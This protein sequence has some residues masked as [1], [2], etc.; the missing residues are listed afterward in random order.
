MSRG[1]AADEAVKVFVSYSH[2]DA[3]KKD[4][5]LT[6]L[7]ALPRELRVITDVWHDRQMYPGDRFDEDIFARIGQAD[8]F[9]ALI[10]RYYLASDYCREEMTGALREAE[11]RG[12]RVVPVIVGKTASWRDYPI[13]RHLALPPDGRAPTDWNDPDEHWAA[14]EQGLKE[15]FGELA[16][17]R[18]TP[19]L[20]PA[21]RKPAPPTTK[22]AG[23]D[24]PDPEPDWASDWGDDRYGRWLEF[25]VDDSA[26][27]APVV[28][29]LRWI[30]PGSFTMGSPATEAGR[31]DDET[32]HRV[33]LSRGFWLADTAC[34]QALW[35]AVMG[36]NP[37]TFE[38]ADRPV[39]QVSWADV[40]QFIARLNERLPG[41]AACLPTEAQ[42]EYAC[43]AGTR[44][45]FSTGETITR[46]QANYDGKETVAVEALPC[47]DWG[48][49]QM[50][51]NVWEWCSDWYDYYPARAVTDPP[52]PDSG[53]ERVLRGGSWNYNPAEVRSA[54]R[55]G[56]APG[57]RDN[58]IGFRLARSP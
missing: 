7:R 41:L 22:P 37:S 8:I 33:T 16:K 3:D 57:Y 45:P 46:A 35:R 32:P 6:C 40:Q 27:G 18:K 15:L 19:P 55:A 30:A 34:T 13:G 49:Y 21:P 28:Q 26:G 10:S 48:L 24:P 20:E 9:L 56:R 1:P 50:H 38:G 12:C 29:R 43:R 36:E 53:E 39:E 23:A 58:S 14:V 42:W 54:S 17:R 25:L 11:Q 44:T 5:V 52:G 47:N 4:E 51:G 2:L 31:D